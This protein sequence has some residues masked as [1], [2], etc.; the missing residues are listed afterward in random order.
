[1][2]GTLEH[3]EREFQKTLGIDTHTQTGAG[4]EK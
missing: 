4:V 2:S 1:M 3:L